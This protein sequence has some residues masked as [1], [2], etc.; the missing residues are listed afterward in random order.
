MSSN[1]VNEMS[2]HYVQIS[3]QKTSKDIVFRWYTAGRFL[4][5][6][7]SEF[8]GDDEKNEWS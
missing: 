5:C 6:L 8:F 3:S 7:Y 2:L 1:E 4:L